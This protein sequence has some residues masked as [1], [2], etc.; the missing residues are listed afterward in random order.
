MY[1]VLG[2]NL[3]LGNGLEVALRVARKLQDVLRPGM[4][5]VTYYMLCH[6][7]L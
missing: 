3:A 7:M 4:H 2:V 6:K 1:T 5:I